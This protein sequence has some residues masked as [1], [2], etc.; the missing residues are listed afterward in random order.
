VGEK[1]RIGVVGQFAN[2]AGKISN[3]WSNPMPGVV[4]GDLKLI[5]FS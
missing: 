3:S 1:R 2:I 5:Q 4:N